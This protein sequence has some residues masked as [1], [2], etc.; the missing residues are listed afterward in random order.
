MSEHIK[1][2]KKLNK[3]GKALLGEV[4]SALSLVTYSKVLPYAP[5]NE[6]IYLNLNPATRILEVQG[7]NDLVDYW[8]VKCMGTSYETKARHSVNKSLSMSR[9]EA[10]GKAFDSIVSLFTFYDVTP[11]SISIECTNGN[12]AMVANTSQ[13]RVTVIGVD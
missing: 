2:Q 6:N 4:V 3:V 8:A 12:V 13:G 7:K 5:S 1:L 9:S 11:F 10:L